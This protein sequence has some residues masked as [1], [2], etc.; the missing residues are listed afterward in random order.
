[1]VFKMATSLFFLLG[2]LVPVDFGTRLGVSLAAPKQVSK[3]YQNGC[4]FL[5]FEKIRR[6]CSQ[7]EFQVTNL[8]SCGEECGEIFGDKFYAWFAWRKST[9]KL[10]PKIH[11]ISHPPNFK[12]HHL[13]LLGPLSRIDILL[14]QKS[15][16]TKVPRIFRIF[17]PNFAPNVAPNL[18]DF[19]E[20]FSCFVSWE[21]ETRKIS[22]KIP[23]IFQCK[24]PRQNWR[25]NPQLFSGEQAK[26]MTFCCLF[27]LVPVWVPPNSQGRNFPE[28]ILVKKFSWKSRIFWWIFRWIFSCSFFQGTWPEKIHEKIHQKN[29]TPKSTSNFREGASLT[30]T[31]LKTVT[32]LNKEPRLL[33][34]P[35]FLSDN[36]I[37]GQGVKMLQMLWSQGYN[38]LQDLQML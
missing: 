9:E 3:Q 5:S 2:I 31:P 12:F 26:K 11:R 36:S 30:R 35:F 34:F 1:M 33:R 29:Q 27:V 15:C 19:F 25:K 13:E 7:S 21:T 23:A 24:I 8:F 14:G 10:P 22:P 6:G 16:R 20:E 18:P 28:R 17:V 32:S 4:F 38:S 37:W